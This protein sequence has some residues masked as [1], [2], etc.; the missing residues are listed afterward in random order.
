MYFIIN[1]YDYTDEKALERRM[2][3]REEHMKGVEAMQKSGNY[4]MAGA[5]LNTEG[6]MCGST[7]FA[8][9]ETRQELDT[10]LEKEP[11]VLQK[12]W[13]RVEIIECKIPPVFLK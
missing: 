2:T 10:W 4:L 3:A 11:Y 7:I 1:G 8:D 13:E 9:F 5:M 6:N 12:V